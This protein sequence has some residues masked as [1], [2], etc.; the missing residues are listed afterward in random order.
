MGDAVVLAERVS[1]WRPKWGDDATLEVVNHVFDLVVAV[2]WNFSILD[3]IHVSLAAAFRVRMVEEQVQNGGYYQYFWNGYGP[4]ADAAVTDFELMGAAGLARVHRD[5]VTKFH[6]V[7]DQLNA[8]RELPHAPYG[9]AGPYQDGLVI[10][11]FDA[12]DEA[13]D[14]EYDRQPVLGLINTW[15]GQRGEEV[16][17]AVLATQY[18]PGAV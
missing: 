13:W 17:N 12:Q 7:A 14:T 2:E 10:E 11:S 1:T 15:L 9:V 16:S 5:A 3:R 8:L 4:V 6:L 18:L